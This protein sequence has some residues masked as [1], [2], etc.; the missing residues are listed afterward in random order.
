M[1]HKIAAFGSP[2]N[3]PKNGMHPD[4]R[5]SHRGALTVMV[6]IYYILFLCVAIYKMI[7]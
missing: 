1:Y 2:Q 4:G 3:R 5:Q 7:T 6:T